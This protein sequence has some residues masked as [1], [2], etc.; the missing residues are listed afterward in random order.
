MVNDLL[1]INAPYPP[2]VEPDV[3][4]SRIRLSCKLSPQA[5]AGL[6]DTPV[7]FS[8]DAGTGCFR[9]GLERDADCGF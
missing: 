6:T 9:Q 5:F 3:R 2:L 4:I 1:P 7:P 8:S